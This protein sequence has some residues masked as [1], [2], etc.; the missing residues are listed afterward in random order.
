MR[1]VQAELLAIAATAKQ[2]P[3]PG[4]PEIA[5]AGRS[6]VGKSSLLNLLT[7]RKKLAYISGTPGK[8]RT[9]N[10]YT[11]NN[12]SFRIVDL[13]GYG[14]AK[15]SKKEAEQWGPM[16]E[17]YLEGRKDLRCV[18]HLV[19]IRHEPSAQDKQMHEYLCY[20]GLAGPIIATKEDKITRNSLSK[21]VTMIRESFGESEDALVLPVS[22]LKKTGVED[23]V[24]AIGDR[25]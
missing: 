14:Y 13:P 24:Q 1:I 12:D 5:F 10:F 19:D 3:K 16:V 17:E 22:A 11:V 6:N 20:H 15:V 2:Y 25:I 21:Q 7:N 18:F 8:T 23:L 9:I 4:P